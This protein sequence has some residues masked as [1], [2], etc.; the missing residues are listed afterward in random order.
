M[1]GNFCH[2]FRTFVSYCL[3]ERCV[4][5]DQQELGK[6]AL[7]GKNVSVHI[8][9]HHFVS[10]FFSLDLRYVYP[11]SGSPLSLREQLCW[12]EEQK[13]IRRLLFFC[14]IHHL[15]SFS[16]FHHDAKHLHALCR[17]ER[18]LLDANLL[19]VL[20]LGLLR[21]HVALSSRCHLDRRY[22]STTDTVRS[23]RVNDL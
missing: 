10:L 20:P 13:N 15:S 21:M 6:H 19:H 12:S 23:V 4:F 1:P 8:F 7:L 17:L 16:S 14:R 18:L 9:F 5:L 2:F 3:N 11:S 22:L